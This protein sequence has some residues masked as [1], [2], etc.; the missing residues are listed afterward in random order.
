MA[1]GCR[2]DP[3]YRGRIDS[4]GRGTGG[5]CGALQGASRP[6]SSENDPECLTEGLT[7]EAL[8]CG[9]DYRAAKL[10]II[11]G[12]WLA[13]MPLGRRRLRRRPRLGIS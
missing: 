4:G 12:R 5:A 7:G 11:C 13:V 1:L 2:K 6:D 8:N 9:G 10:A 3:R